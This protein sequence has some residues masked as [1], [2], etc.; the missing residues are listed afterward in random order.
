MLKYILQVNS[1]CHKYL[2]EATC[3]TYFNP[4][5]SPP[6]GYSCRDHCYDVQ[7]SC[8]DLIIPYK[9]FNMCEFYPTRKEYDTCFWPKVRCEEPR[10]PTHGSVVFT[11]VTFRS[12]AKYD[13]NALFKLEGN[14]I[15]TC[16]VQSSQPEKKIKLKLHRFC[17]L[18]NNNHRHK[19]QRSTTLLNLM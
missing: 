16:Q 1:G 3:L 19:E 9:E 11:N 7:E 12:Q 15:R 17:R 13:C 6:G 10:A 14:N 18:S 4:C 2:R 5:D 8:P